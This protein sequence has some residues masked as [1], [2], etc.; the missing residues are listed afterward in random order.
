MSQSPYA[1]LPGSRPPTPVKPK[2]SA[3][4]IILIIL[5]V[6]LGGSVLGCGCCGGFMYWGLGQAGRQ[7]ADQVRNHPAIVEHI[8]SDVTCS[9][10]IMATG[11]EAEKRPGEQWVVFDA[12]G[13]KGQGQILCKQ[14]PGGQPTPTILQT[15]LGDFPLTP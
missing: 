2:G 9:M 14:N 4:K 7:I 1:P 6:V 5:G 15:A 11:Q 3:G 12:K 13:S 8:G 10:N